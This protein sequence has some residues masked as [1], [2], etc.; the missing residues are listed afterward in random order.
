MSSK[1]LSSQAFS[2]KCQEFFKPGFIWHRDEAVAFVKEHYTVQLLLP[3]EL[4]RQYPHYSASY[5]GFIEIPAGFVWFAPK[6]VAEIV[7]AWGHRFFGAP[8]EQCAFEKVQQ[9]LRTLLVFTPDTR[10]CTKKC[11][12][13]QHHKKKSSRPDNRFWILSEK[14]CFQLKDFFPTSTS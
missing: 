7:R 10:I 3:S 8:F 13:R 11:I 1:D 6:F 14:Q 4:L 9:S 12:T 5:N 2:F